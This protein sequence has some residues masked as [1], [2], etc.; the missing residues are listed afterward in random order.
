[1]NCLSYLIA[2]SIVLT[3]T[4][5]FTVWPPRIITAG[6][7][8]VRASPPRITLTAVRNST[9]AFS[10]NWVT[11]CTMDTGAGDGT[12]SS[13]VTLDTGLVAELTKITT[14]T[15]TRSCF[16]KKIM[17]NLLH[18]HINCCRW[19]MCMAVKWLDTP[20]VHRKV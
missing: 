8:T 7:T 17:I 9:C 18:V 14:T 12:V 4:S 13:P 15:G 11:M 1:M 6:H 10:I 16:K 19:E 5:I 2:H 20:L 3:Q